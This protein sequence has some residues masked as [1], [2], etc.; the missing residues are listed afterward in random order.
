MPMS[1]SCRDVLIEKNLSQVSEF[2]SANL[3]LL[4]LIDNESYERYRSE[5]GGGYGGISGDYENFRENLDRQRRLSIM[6]FS[7]EHALSALT[8]T[9]LPEA[10][11][12]WIQ[13]MRANRRGLFCRLEGNP[14]GTVFLLTIEWVPPI[15]LG[16]QKLK[17]VSEQITSEKGAAKYTENIP[18]TL[19]E[20]THTFTIT[21]SEKNVAVYGHIRGEVG[22]TGGAHSTT[23]YI[24]PVA[25]TLEENPYYIADHPESLIRSEGVHGRLQFNRVSWQEEVWIS[26]VRY[27]H[28]IGMHPPDKSSC[29]AEFS[30]PR[31]ARYF[32][33]IFGM[34]R[35][36]EKPGAHGRALGKV[37][38][39]DELVWSATL[40]GK[41]V[42]Q[43]HAIGIPIGAKVLRL[44]TD[45]LGTNWGDH[46]T[47]V[48]S[49]F[50]GE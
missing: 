8:L 7:D 26:D 50:S 46:A 2:R 6:E 17:K 15:G 29:F 5:I 4:S 32:R 36:D 20:G 34:A 37:L 3:F 19:G 14:E 12:A 47:W 38:I 49:H 43:T 27:S 9:G 18:E 11:D 40:S 48:E 35:F 1:D 42:S 30:I 24:P 21:R 31:H 39:D 33:S 41:S 23:F 25:L 22:S 44:E 45:S 13:C 16:G 28:A 10:T